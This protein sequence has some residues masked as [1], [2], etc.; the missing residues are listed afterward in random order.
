MLSAVF[1]PDGARVLT[2]S[3]DKTA[4][5]WEA[6][7]GKE[8]A[9]LRGHEGGVERGVLARWRAGADRVVGQDGAAVGGGQRQGAGGPA[10]P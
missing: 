5:L 7:S 8:L 9:V 1:S 10:R 6:A 2:A 3:E 4:R